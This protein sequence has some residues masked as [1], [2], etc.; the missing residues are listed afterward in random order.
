MKEKALKVM[1]P[2]DDIIRETQLYTIENLEKIP[3]DLRAMII[4]P[5]QE[6]TIDIF[7]AIIQHIAMKQEEDINTMKKQEHIIT[8][9]RRGLSRLLSV[10]RIRKSK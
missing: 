7:K 8:R 10:R 5:E 6:Q 2:E 4:S 3:E 9:N 1:Q